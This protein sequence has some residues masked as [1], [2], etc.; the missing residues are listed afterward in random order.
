[1]LRDQIEYPD[2]L[3]LVLPSLVSL[4]E[5]STDEDYRNIIQPEF[6]KVIC[7]TRPVQVCKVMTRPVQVGKVMTRQVQVGK[8]MT[9]PE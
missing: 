8:F 3:V 2:M 1:M 7:M 4:I 9:R 6:R 5:F